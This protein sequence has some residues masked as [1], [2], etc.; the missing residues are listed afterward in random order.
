MARSPPAVARL[1]FQA[2]SVIDAANL[3]SL[4]GKDKGE[5]KLI[6]ELI[7]SGA[8][9]PEI[10]AELGCSYAAVIEAKRVVQKKIPFRKPVHDTNSD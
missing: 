4:M 6:I 9:N 3:G 10:V 2:A 8:S 7:K 1:K 5:R